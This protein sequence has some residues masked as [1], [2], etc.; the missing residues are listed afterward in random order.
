MGADQIVEIWVKGI[1]K[2]EIKSKLI[3]VLSV[4]ILS[5]KKG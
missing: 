3:L 4:M 1:K 5:L 2:D